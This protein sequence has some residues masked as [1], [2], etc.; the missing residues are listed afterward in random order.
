MLIFGNSPLIFNF[1]NLIYSIPMYFNADNQG[2]CSL[3]N[4]LSTKQHIQIQDYMHLTS[5]Q[6]N[7]SSK[8]LFNFIQDVT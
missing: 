8:T 5:S 3:A 6:K 1:N 2:L 7:F 4:L